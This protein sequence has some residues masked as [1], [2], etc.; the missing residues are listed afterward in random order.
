MTLEERKAKADALHR[1][2]YNCTQS[3][4]LSFSDVTGMPDD[5][6]VRVGTGLGRASGVHAGICG[7]VNGGVVVLGM[8]HAADPKEKL[9][10]VGEIEEVVGEFRRRNDGRLHCTEL[11]NGENMRP[12]GQ[13]IADV[14][15]IMHHRLCE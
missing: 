15:E 6:A 4:L 9:R 14:V 7:A 1:K 8:T 2:G 13:L 12:C 3:V 11:K 10:I 5:I